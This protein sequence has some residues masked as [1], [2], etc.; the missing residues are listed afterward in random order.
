MQ[1]LID[2]NK[3]NGIAGSLKNGTILL[4][5][6]MHAFSAN[7]GTD[8]FKELFSNFIVKSIEIPS[9][10]PSVSLLSK[11][12]EQ[13]GSFA[14]EIIIGFG[15]GTVLDI[16]KLMKVILSIG[17][18]AATIRNAPADF[19]SSIPICAVPT[20]AGTGSE[21]T[22]FAVLYENKVKYS[23]S[24]SQLRPDYVVLD[25]SLVMTMPVSLAVSTGFDAF[26]QAIES[27]WSVR[28]T[29]ESQA[30]SVESLELIKHHFIDSVTAPT[31]DSRKAMQKAA[32]LSGQAI[33]IAQTT[34][35]H[36]ISYPLTSYFGIPHG[37]AVFLLLPSIFEFNSQVKDS[38]C[39]D[40]RGTLFVKQSINRLAAILE[41]NTTDTRKTLER[42]FEIFSIPRMLSAYGIH[43]S[44]HIQ[45]ILDNGFNPQRMKNNPRKIDSTIL[46]NILKGIL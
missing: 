41:C 42:Y 3:L 5:R 11:I 29:E 37:L 43:S 36:A 28:S 8:Y 44:D 9:E 32:Y 19:T 10:L 20:T 46:E 35:A 15:G 6:D 17:C 1:I 12:H 23:I 7:H 33:N 30:Y 38:D 21:A 13:V 34:A 16:C 4:L 31:I 18:T 40:T 25:P 27:Y 45:C 24:N 14:P 22:Q 26:S 2:I 39:I